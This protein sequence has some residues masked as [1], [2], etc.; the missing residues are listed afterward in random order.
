MPTIN[1]TLDEL[2]T[3]AEALC[4]ASAMRVEILEKAQAILPNCEDIKNQRI[5]ESGV[6]K[7]LRKAMRLM[8]DAKA[9]T[10]VP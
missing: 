6:Q 2:L 4:E 8:K 5:Y 1:Q 7:G 9:P 10:T 3:Q